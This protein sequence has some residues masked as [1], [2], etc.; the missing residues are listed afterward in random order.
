MNLVQ[1]EFAIYFEYDLA[2]PPNKLPNS[3]RFILIS[4]THNRTFDIPYGEIL[5]HAGDLSTLSN[6]E[7]GVT[8]NWL[9]SSS[10]PSKVIIAGNHDIMLLREGYPYTN[11]SWNLS[12]SDPDAIHFLC[13]IQ[14]VTNGVYYLQNNTREIGIDRK[15]WK[16]LGSP[17]YPSRRPTK[18][19]NSYES[20][21]ITHGPPRNILD[22]TQSNLHVGCIEL[23]DALPRLRPKL[24]V[25]GHIHESRGFQVVHYDNGDY[26]I[27]VNAANSPV[28]GHYVDDKDKDYNLHAV[29]VDIVNL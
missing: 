6:I 24:H 29:I 9:A 26:T 11:G 13:G 18:H 5:I 23:T 14:G 1:D 7:Y 27:H 3:T 28:G 10:C 17:L 2:A 8:A 20:I 12:H 25:F 22:K 21:T 15:T 4:D 16:I 19:V